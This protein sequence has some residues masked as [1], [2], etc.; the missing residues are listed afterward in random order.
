MPYLSNNWTNTL[1]LLPWE[2]NGYDDFYYIRTPIFLFFSPRFG[3]LW[4]KTYPLF[5]TKVTKICVKSISPSRVAPLGKFKA[6]LWNKFGFVKSGW[7]DVS[8]LT[9]RR[10]IGLCA[11]V[12]ISSLNMLLHFG[13]SHIF[14]SWDTGR[15]GGR[16][17]RARAVPQT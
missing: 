16:F 15:H 17:V 7:G 5:M 14:H 13:W 10:K 8:P 4:E 1:I 12:H 6:Y 11:S 3:Q 2:E 9:Q